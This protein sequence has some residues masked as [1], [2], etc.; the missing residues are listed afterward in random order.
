MAPSVSQ[1]SKKRPIQDMVDE[2]ATTA[3]PDVPRFG[4]AGYFCIELFCG[5]GNLTYAMK[6]FFPD[7]FGIDHKVSKQRVKTICLDLSLKTNQQLVEQWCL[8]GKCL[9]VHWGIPCGTASRARFRRLSRRSHGQP[10]LRTDRWPDGLPS[11]LGV[12]LIRVR[13]ANRLY[14]FMTDLIPK[15]HQMG[16]VWTVENPWTSLVWKTSY[17]KR[18]EKLRPWYC[19]LHNCMFGGSRLKR[20][21]IASNSSSVMSIAIHCDGQHS[22][23][24]WTIQQ[25]VFD[26]SLEAEYTPALAKALAEC[27]LESIAGEY[28]LPNVQQFCKRLKL[29]HFT[30]MAA[31]KQPSKPVAMALT[32]EFSHLIVLS[33]IPAEVQ[34]PIVDKQLSKCCIVDQHNQQWLLPCGSKLLRQTS[35]EGGVSR[36]PK[37]SVERTPSLHSLEGGAKQSGKP[38]VELQCLSGCGGREVLKLETDEVLG[39]CF[40][41]VLGVRWSP[42]QFLKQ[43]CMVK[44]PFDSFSGLPSVVQSA[45]D[46]LA[47]MSMADMVNL[48]CSKLGSWLKLAAQLKDDEAALKSSMGEGR[49]GILKSKRLLLM[50]HIIQQEGYD[51]VSLADDMI[52][53]FSLV[54]EVPRSNVLP[55]KTSPACLSTSDLKSNANRA[56]KA[57]RYMTRSS[58]LSNSS[59]TS[60]CLML[61]ILGWA[62]DRE[63]PKSDTFSTQVSALGVVFDLGPTSS[64]RLEVHNTEKRLKEAVESLDRFIA[65]K[66]LNKRD[67]LTLRGRLAFCDAFVFGRLGKVLLQNITHHAYAKPFKAELD[68]AAMHSLRILRNRMANAKPRRLDLNLLDTFVLM[69]DAAF[70]I[71][72]GA[73]LGAVLVAP[74]GAVAMWFG[75]QLG[76]ERLG[77]FLTEGRQ[78][79][80]GELETLAAAAALMLWGH[81]IS[82]SKLLLFVDNEGARFSLIK[83]YSKSLPITHICALAANALDS[84]CIMPWYS[85]V[86]SLSNL[87]DLPSRN[88]S[89][90][91]LP[92]SLQSSHES[93]VDVVEECLRFVGEPTGHKD[94]MGGGRGRKTGGMNLPPTS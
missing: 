30:A 15:L 83:G 79:I 29:S 41:W 57:L 93:V 75:L 22:H 34:L 88:E 16:V 32:P 85:R 6:H 19:E 60:L 10:P 87:A 52:N 49:R 31:A 73:G 25:G 82:S 37:V 59:Q 58:A 76:L 81:H 90:H 68:D 65:S 20:T 35:K 28:K 66:K 67:A 27:I 23:A 17:W 40:D 38:D 71:S 45:C 36:L 91:L 74:T 51:D 62:F 55:H 9:W 43:A 78:T 13:A 92:V 47:K 69:T 24:P 89:H 50:K 86:P 63:G 7:S 11:L 21:C 12:N 53:G 2:G 61:D 4:E 64:G 26:T 46:D 42:E 80:I 33:N 54:G 5:S 39:R 8:S 1:N 77:V 3:Q 56:N 18:I 84:F 44:H 14:A 48:R 72:K 70:D 94:D